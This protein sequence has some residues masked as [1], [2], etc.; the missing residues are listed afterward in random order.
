LDNDITLEKIKLDNKKAREKTVSTTLI[1]LL[2]QQRKAVCK[3]NV[4]YPHPQWHDN[5]F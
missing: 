5:L 3:K 4:T 2:E 1:L